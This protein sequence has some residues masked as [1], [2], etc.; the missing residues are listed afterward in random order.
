MLPRAGIGSMRGIASGD[1]HVVAV[2]AAEQIDANERLAASVGFAI[3]SVLA[4]AKA[5]NQCEEKICVIM[6]NPAFCPPVPTIG[7]MSIPS[8]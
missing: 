7:K 3:P 4:A 2:V 5:P 1:N 6:P 8:L